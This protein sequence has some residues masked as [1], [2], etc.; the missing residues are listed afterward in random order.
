MLNYGILKDCLNTDLLDKTNIDS[1]IKQKHLNALQQEILDNK[2]NCM[3]GF[4]IEI[5]C[6]SNKFVIY[7]EDKDGYNVQSTMIKIC[8]DKAKIRIISSK[9]HDLKYIE[10]CSNDKKGN[11]KN[12]LLLREDGK[13]NK[14]GNKFFLK[15]PEET[16]EKQ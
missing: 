4:Y 14:M 3:G 15:E 1:F 16:S 13:F 6:E 8:N 9:L 12:Y 7:R 5:Q 11:I 2:L 10:I